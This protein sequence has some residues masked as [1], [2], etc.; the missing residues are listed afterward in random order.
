MLSHADLLAAA[1]FH[2]VERATRDLEHDLPLPAFD[3][4]PGIFI[5]GDDLLAVRAGDRS[6]ADVRLVDP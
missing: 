3:H 6:R 4:V 1:G 5:E 2:T